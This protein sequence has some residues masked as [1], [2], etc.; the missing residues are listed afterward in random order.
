MNK[1][2]I[3]FL[4]LMEIKL[5]ITGLISILHRITGILLFFLMPVILLCFNDILLYEVSFNK[6]VSFSQ[7]FYFSFLLILF[8]L[9]FFYHVFAGVRH[10]L[11]DFGYGEEN[12]HKIKSEGSIF[13]S[14]FSIFFILLVVYMGINL[15]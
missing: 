1:K 2:R 10:I 13:L 3:M 12:K 15:W 11:I 7:G 9:I 8:F 5:P 4:N 6:F 14:L